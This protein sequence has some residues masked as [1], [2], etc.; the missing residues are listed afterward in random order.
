MDFVHKVK[1]TKY[2]NKYL[3]LKKNILTNSNIL[4]QS[5]FGGSN[6]KKYLL[7]KIFDSQTIKKIIKYIRSDRIE[8]IFENYSNNYDKIKELL[9]VDLYYEMFLLNKDKIQNKYRNI[10][11]I[12]LYLKNNLSDKY[13]ILIEKFI[14]DLQLE[15][16]SWESFYDS[17]IYDNMHLIPNKEFEKMILD[18]Y[19]IGFMN[20]KN[21][22]KSKEYLENNY[23]KIKSQIENDN[24][25]K[26]SNLD[27][28][29]PNKY[30]NHLNQMN[31]LE[32]IL[33][34][35]I[36]KLVKE[37][38]D[39]IKIVNLLTTDKDKFLFLYEREIKKK[40]NFIIEL[41]LC[42]NC[43]FELLDYKY[44]KLD[45]PNYN[46]FIIMFDFGNNSY[47]GSIPDKVNKL[48]KPYKPIR[49]N[50]YGYKYNDID[51]DEPEDCE[52]FEIIYK[53]KEYYFLN[54]LHYFN[55]SRDYIKNIYSD[56]Y[57]NYMELDLNIENFTEFQKKFFCYFIKLCFANEELYK[58]WNI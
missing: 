42:K 34:I 46:N 53:T 26:I 2:K 10:N 38:I 27:F 51:F 56:F 36:K 57:F 40:I 47:M 7:E 15:F 16:I 5:Q 54:S 20:K 58:D 18:I 6:D 17:I 29:L 13:F 44:Y 19:N 45:N 28:E 52:Y 48:N 37:I 35:D 14:E 4:S 49:E 43:E 24:L 55:E 3:E 33:N 32:N 1:Y 11:Q 31:N 22:Y 41:D 12:K 30:F 25:K 21:Y 50:N 39:L 8:W 23:Q 9:E